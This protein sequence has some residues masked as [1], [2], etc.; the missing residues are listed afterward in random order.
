MIEKEFF[1]LYKLI[2]LMI[3]KGKKTK[4]INVFLKLLKNLNN[5]KLG[6]QATEVISKSLSNAKPLLHV[7]K[8]RKSSRVFYLPKL[9]STEQKINIAL[10]WLMKSVSARKERKLEDRLTNEI[11]DCFLGKGSTIAKKQ[12]LYEL[13]LVNRPFLHLLRYK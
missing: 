4:A 9:V 2:H 6:L 3:K 12:S 1:I 13:I 5:N 7:Q 11:L 10:H 8:T